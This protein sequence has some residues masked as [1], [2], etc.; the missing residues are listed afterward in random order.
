[1][2]YFTHARLGL[3]LLPLLL[4]CS[5]GLGLTTSLRGVARAVSPRVWLSQKV[6]APTASLLVHGSGFGLNETVLVDFDDTT[7]IGSTTTDATGQFVVQV[8]VP[9]TAL[10][11]THT[12]RT[13]WTQREDST[14]ELRHQ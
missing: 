6:G 14:V 8:T 10:P 1:M 13:D 9:K 3:F 4:V 5:S 2:R 7:Q 12:V 11:G